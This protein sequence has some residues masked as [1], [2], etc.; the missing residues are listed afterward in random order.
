MCYG[1]LV[2]DNVLYLIMEHP[3]GTWN[4]CFDAYLTVNEYGSPCSYLL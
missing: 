2:G 3:L 4:T 1:I